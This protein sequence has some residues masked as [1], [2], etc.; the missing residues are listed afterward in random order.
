MRINFIFIALC[1]F[2]VVIIG[3]LV[4]LQIIQGEKYKAWAE[5]RLFLQGTVTGE[6]GEIFFK[7]GESLAI[8]KKFFSVFASPSEVKDQEK[9]ADTLE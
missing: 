7:N 9:T 1:L 4:N 5:G 8:N 3:Q 6:R 2:G